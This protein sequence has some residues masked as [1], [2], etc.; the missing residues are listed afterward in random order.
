V[1]DTITV[2]VEFKVRL[3]VTPD[4]PVS[5]AVEVIVPLRAPLGAE[6]VV[7]SQGGPEVEVPWV[8]VAT[9]VEL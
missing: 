7:K 9:T 5:S 4:M 2:L 1:V 6:P 8:S 3:T